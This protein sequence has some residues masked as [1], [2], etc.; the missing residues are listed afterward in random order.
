MYIVF[1]IGGTKTRIS[2]SLDGE[3]IETP[4]VFPTPASFDEGML[5]FEDTVTDLARGQY[6]T[7][8]AGGIAGPLDKAKTKV[9]NAPNLQGWIHKPLKRTLEE[10]FHTTVFLENDAALA[11]L[12]EA[13]FG[14]AKQKS[15]IAYLTIST[16]VGGARIVDG[17]IDRNDR[18]FEPGHHVIDPKGPV[19]LGCR[20]KG[21]L[22]ALIGGAS[23]TK[24]YGKRPEDINDPKI[25]DEVAYWLALGLNNVLVFWSPDI[26]VLGGSLIS[27]IALPNV[28]IYLREW[29][30]IYA[31]LPPI[32]PSFL[33]ESGLYGA[34]A[35]LKFEGNPFSH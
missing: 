6:I 18:G 16:G 7:G 14:V 10:K 11:G 2:S 4:L 24:R 1:D 23:L 21:H 22:E 9:I 8:I 27:K 5:L 35:L 17:K 12:G 3:R 29:C 19:C 13:H 33:P 15:I 20:K 26:V 25:W 34:L 31:D 32:I 30:Q 28:A